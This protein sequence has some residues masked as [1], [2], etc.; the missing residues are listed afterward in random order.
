MCQRASHVDRR[1]FTL[2][3]LLAVFTTAC[4]RTE[5]PPTTSIARPAKPVRIEPGPGQ[6]VPQRRQR[7]H[8][9]PEAEQPLVRDAQEF[10]QHQES[11]YGLVCFKIRINR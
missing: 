7:N 6:E 8:R 5:E 9:D 4:N 10:E 2:A 3:L 11:I 1:Y